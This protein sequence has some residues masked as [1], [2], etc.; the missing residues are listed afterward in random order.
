MD[1]ALAG[2]LSSQHTSGLLWGEGKAHIRSYCLQMLVKNL[3]A[4]SLEG[5]PQFGGEGYA[6]IYFFPF[7]FSL[8]MF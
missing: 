4:E 8:D 6:G 1:A 7:F 3:E 2:A 5:K